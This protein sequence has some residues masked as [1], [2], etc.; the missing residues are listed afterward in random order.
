M[1]EG[2]DHDKVFIY[3]K[4]KK[5]PA[6]GGS[7]FYQSDQDDGPVVMFNSSKKRSFTFNGVTDKNCSFKS[8]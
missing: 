6:D 1:I 3:Y 2:Y 8:F 5:Y 7:Y 4:G